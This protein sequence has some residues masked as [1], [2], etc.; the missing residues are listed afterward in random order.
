VSILDPARMTAILDLPQDFVFIGHLCVGYP[1]AADDTPSLERE[2]WEH[3]H[4]AEG[5]VLYR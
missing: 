3:R 1:L 5:V 4:P 2:G